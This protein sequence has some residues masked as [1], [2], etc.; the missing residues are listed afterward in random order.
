M[1]IDVHEKMALLRLQRLHADIAHTKPGIGTRCLTLLLSG[2]GAFVGLML[3][4]GIAVA[5]G[6]KKEWWVPISLIASLGIWGSGAILM[7]RG[8]ARK[9]GRRE[10][11]L[12]QQLTIA[13]QEVASTLPRWVAAV[14]GPET[15]LDS[16]R[17]KDLLVALRSTSVVER[18][19]AVVTPS[20][21]G[22]AANPTLGPSAA[23]AEM[24]RKTARGFLVGGIINAIV[25]IAFMVLVGPLCIFTFALAALELTYASLFWSTPPSSIHDPTWVATV[26]LFSLFIGSLW[27]F[28]IGV[29]NLKRLRAPETKAYMRALRAGLQ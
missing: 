12:R 3:M 26:E 21:Q 25:G 11:E 20:P 7:Q 28:A 29:A 14:G 15:L 4:G 22:F 8:A 24:L 1:E 5:M 6:A 17:F 23:G 9:A 16:Q 27:S 2:V 10:G 18:A 13:I 19:P